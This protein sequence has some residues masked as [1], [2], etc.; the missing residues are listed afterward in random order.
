[1]KVFIANRL[2]NLVEAMAGR[3]TTPLAGTLKPETIVVQSAGMAKW[4]SLK[5]ALHHGVAANYRFPF[6][7]AFIEEIFHAFIPEYEKNPIFEEGVM[8]WRILDLLL[9]FKNQ[10]QFRS[11]RKYL[12]E[13]IDQNRLYQMANRIAR[14]FDQY[15]IFRPD[16]ILQWE[17][18]NVRSPDDEWQAILW[19]NIPRKHGSLH[20][21]ALRRQLI[22]AMQNKPCRQEVLPE[23]LSVFGISYLPPYHLDILVR[24]AAHMPVDYYYL[25]PTQEFWADIKSGREITRMVHKIPGKGLDW[26]DELHLETGN[27][28]LASWGAQGRDFFRMM[29]DMPVEYDDLFIDVTRDSLLHKVQD[30]IYRLR[31]AQGEN[32]KKEKISDS[33]ETIQIHACY[34]PLREVEALHDI[35]LNLFEKDSSLAPE[36]VLV[37]TPDIET[38]APCIEAVFEAREPKIPYSIADRSA[39]ASNTIASGLMSLLDIAGSRFKASDVLALLDNPAVSEKFDMTPENRELIH[40]WIDQTLIKWGIDEEHRTSF[41]LP[42]FG[43]N[44]WKHGLDRLLAGVVFDGRNPE[45]YAGILPYGEIESDQTE[46]LGR[47]LSLWEKLVELKIIVSSKHSLEEWCGILKTIM[48]DFLSSFDEYRNEHNLINQV[49]S[50]LFTEQEQAGCGVS[51]DMSVIRSYVQTALERSGGG[52]RFLAGGVSFCA[53]LPMRSI[54]FDVICL[55]GMNSDAYPR[56]ESKTGFNVMENERRAGDRSLRNDDQY[57]FLESILSARKS[58]IITYVGLS[59]MDNSVMLPSVLVSD[60]TDY[61][62]RNYSIENSRFPSDGMLRNHPLHAFSPVYFTEGNALFS[63]SK[64]NYLS[65]CAITEAKEGKKLFLN[66]PLVPVQP[67]EKTIT[68]HKLMRFYMDPV[69][70]FLELQIGLKLPDNLWAETQDSEP[71]HIDGL[72]AYQIKKELIE[73]RLKDWDDRMV[74]EKKRAQGTL[75]VGVAGDYLFNDVRIG[76]AALAQDITKYFKSPALENLDVDFASGEYQICG[77]VDSLHKDFRVSYRPAKMKMKDFLNAWIIHVILNAAGPEDYP[78]KSLL[79]GEDGAWR[80]EPVPNAAD[81][82]QILIQYY[83]LGHTKPLKLFARS[84]WAYASALWQK[85]K[86]MEAALD[87]A[88]TAWEG[89]DNDFI[90]ADSH[91]I[92]CRICFEDLSPIDAEFQKTAENILKELFVHMVKAEN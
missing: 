76:A 66:A 63:Y 87:A 62:D 73:S 71:F 75:P 14:T 49:I 82:L 53:M 46:V 79:V 86:S 27:S 89:Y 59:Q 9:Q 83:L 39:L 1:M 60:F 3:L 51:L 36:D 92:A 90:Q 43:Q 56:R 65:A 26:K 11:I 91:E 41:N 19:R 72:S 37:M 47:F 77:A 44:T 12:G 38:Y 88:Q 48:T 58:L 64:S 28:L 32:G 24:L 21:A 29:E 70:Y 80:F 23:R 50:R 5:L 10:E 15:L 6:P 2:E 7:N 69:R 45:I 35:L 54:P 13:G 33:D 74:L 85:N 8:V 42:A 40:H 17:E 78:K 68:I 67:P 52:A 57:L 25:N 18:G 30:D 31:E 34:S 84:S 20:K 61:L 4:I 81:I 16:M 55:I 22:S